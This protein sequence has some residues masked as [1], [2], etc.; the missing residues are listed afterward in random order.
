MRSL[1]FNGVYELRRHDFLIISQIPVKAKSSRAE[2]K[3][4]AKAEGTQLKSH[5]LICIAN[6]LTY[7][8]T[9]ALELSIQTALP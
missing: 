1:K 8:W 3:Q 6:S 9:S 4:W 2:D 5:R 7:D